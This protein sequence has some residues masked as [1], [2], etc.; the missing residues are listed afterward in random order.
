[1]EGAGLL[2]RG[3]PWCL[4]KPGTGGGRA[5]PRRAREDPVRVKLDCFG[6]LWRKRRGL[7]VSLGFAVY[8]FWPF[9][10]ISGLIWAERLVK[11]CCLESSPALVPGEGF[12]KS[13]GGLLRSLLSS[14]PDLTTPPPSPHPLLTFTCVW[15]GRKVQDVFRLALIARKLYC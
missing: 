11:S 7:P 4:N 9:G 2:G 8:Q 1:M 13:W 14:G 6:F 12:K 3:W 5:R 15:T 10:R